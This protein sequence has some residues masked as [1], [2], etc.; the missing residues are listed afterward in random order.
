M[1]TNKLVALIVTGL[2]AASPF[3]SAKASESWEWALTPYLWMPSVSMDLNTKAPPGGVGTDSSFPNIL[4]DIQGG[5]LFHVEGQG[6]RFGMFG[7]VMW[8]SLG[9]GRDFADF[10]TD[11]NLD[12]SIWELAGVWNVEPERFD[13][14]EL[15]F[16]V[17]YFDVGLDIE[18]DPVNPI[19]SNIKLDGGSHY[20]DYMLGVRY[21]GSFS[22]NWGYVLRADG[23]WGD[24]TGT[25]NLAG[26]LTYKTGSGSWA[27]GYRYLTTGLKAENKT[28]NTLNPNLDL[29]ITLSGPQLSYTWFIK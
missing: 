21:I 8:L 26:N 9:K 18:F 28:V 2:M 6:E 15:L 27:F 11:T 24:T 5:F 3:A 22:G 1:R 20:L 7:D 10:S 12:A 14:L 19:Y 25:T 17:R 29:D 13:G 16:G 23:S 4:D